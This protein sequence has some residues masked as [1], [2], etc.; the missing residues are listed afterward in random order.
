VKLP[1]VKLVVGLGNPGSEYEYSP[2]N[3]GFAV[4]D[5]L[6]ER[7]HVSLT[8]RKAR[9]LCGHFQLGSEK[10]WLIQPQ[11]FM[12]NSGAAVAEWFRKEGCGPEDLVVL[13]DELDL[14][15][16]TI[17][18][19]QRGGSA[20]HHGLESIMQ[21]IGTKAFTRMRI[22]VAPER[23]LN[24]PVS[25]LLRPVR[26][27]RRRSLGPIVNRAADAAEMILREGAAKAMNRFN[28]RDVAAEAVPPPASSGR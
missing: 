14:P 17:Q 20:G 16:G 9:S 27:E 26:T 1:E 25:Y 7:H 4:V 22:G 8:R 23:E 11:T 5:R 6:T 19:R 18:I 13:A 21:A 3:M 28:R 10:I 24:D 15:W 12:N 2:H